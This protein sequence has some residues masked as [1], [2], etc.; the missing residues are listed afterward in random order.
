MS[1]ET[2]VVRVSG[3]P[4]AGKTHTLRER[5]DEKVA[6]GL[7]VGR[8][9]WLNFSNAGRKDVAPEIEA[10]FSRVDTSDARDDPE[11]RAKTFHGLSLSLCIRRGLI[12]GGD[13]PDQIIMQ[14]Q[15]LGGVVDPYADFCERQC[16]RYDAR[17]A[18]PR[19]LLSGEKGGAV[20]G[21]KLFAVNDYLTQTCKPISK[22][23]QS[24]IDISI[25]DAQVEKLLEAWDDYKKEPP[26][27]DVDRRLF[28]HG[29]YV[30]LAY[31]ARL[32]PDVDMLFIDEFQDLAP[33]EYQL[34]VLWRD[35][36]GI[37]TV[38]IAGD[39]NQSLYSFRGGTPVYFRKTDV[40]DETVLT[41]SRR[42]PEN[43][44]R[45]G[46][47]ILSTHPDT[48]PRG[49]GGYDEGGTVRW[50]TIK[51]PG[52]IHDAVTDSV[53][54]HGGV[55]SVLLLTRTNYQIYELTKV[56][57]K[58]GVPFD[59][60]GA[61]GGV[62][63]DK[64]GNIL[65]FLNTF[66]NDGDNFPMEQVKPTLNAL[67]ESK[68][69]KR[70]MADPLGGHLNGVVDQEGI[71]PAVDDFDSV[72]GIVEWMDLEG[73]RRDILTNAVENPT[74]IPLGSV[75]V[76]TMHTSKG[77]EAPAV[78]LFTETNS[79]LKERYQMSNAQAAE[80]HRTYYV[81]A[82]RAS[83]ELHLVDGFFDN[84]TAPP[85]HKARQHSEVPL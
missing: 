81:G 14:G 59:I 82:T 21:N 15:R 61:S 13:D 42:C 49:F 33:A 77:L 17:A 67:P 32:I 20:P 74:N 57:K 12:N 25:A 53:R 7:G 28:E 27:D 9:F 76:G 39:P 70:R 55:P 44:A 2:R 43:I 11:D 23:K 64:L 4:G 51:R 26:L 58:W 72:G 1:Q 18:D 71:R 38:Y 29:D 85:I 62:W 45:V 56:L 22:W 54:T 48:D 6:N 41:D 46:S 19:K 73:W 47:S 16:M 75:R 50:D 65:T 79:T 40:D 8:F 83:E 78:Y 68:E 66:K 24:G 34:Y 69:R 10:A 31:D 84:E 80:E 52:G 37:E 63:D 30:H 36:A 35:Y 3:A 60:L 5:L